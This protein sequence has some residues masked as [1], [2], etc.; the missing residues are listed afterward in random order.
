MLLSLCV[1]QAGGVVEGSLLVT[2]AT[3][4][5]LL[6]VFTLAALCPVA[7]G[8]GALWGIVASHVLTTWMAAGRLLY[9]TKREKNLPVSVEVSVVYSF[10]VTVARYLCHSHGRKIFAF[11]TSS[12]DICVPDKVRRYLCLCP[13]HQ[14]F[15]FLSQSADI[16]VPDKVA[17]YFCS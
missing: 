15:A 1:G 4:G 16:C 14:M 9:V 13:G 7:N 8:T 10:P 12:S 11:F 17:R 6:G 5:A 3:S 2:S